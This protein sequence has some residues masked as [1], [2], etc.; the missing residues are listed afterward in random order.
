MKDIPL[1]FCLP[2]P[3]IKVVIVI[4]LVTNIDM[5]HFMVV[6]VDYVQSKEVYWLRAM[7]FL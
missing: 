7:M 5:S 3:L 4:E 1:I 2:R 6:L